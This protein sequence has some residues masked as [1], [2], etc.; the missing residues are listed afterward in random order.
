MESKTKILNAVKYIGSTILALGVAIFLYGFFV[1]N[2]GSVTGIGIGTVMGAVFI[3]LMGVF[4][5][6]T[7][8]MQEKANQ[9]VR[10][11]P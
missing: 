10:L 3:F 1:S 11:D 2:Y 6:A 8:E 4:F 9:R 7:E 5:V